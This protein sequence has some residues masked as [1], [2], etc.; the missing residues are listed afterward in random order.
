MGRKWVLAFDLVFRYFT[1]M[2]S[3]V[4]VTLVLEH[5]LKDLGQTEWLRTFLNSTWHNRLKK[6]K[7]KMQY[8][9]LS[10]SKVELI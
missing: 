6:K 4:W 9:K 1:D 10:M 2:N 7:K 8:L 3:S 5:R